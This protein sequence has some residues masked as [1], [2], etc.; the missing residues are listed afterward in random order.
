MKHAI[1]GKMNDTAST[2][3]ERLKWIYSTALCYKRNAVRKQTVDN[4][5]ALSEGKAISYINAD[6][7]R[8]TERR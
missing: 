6:K 2:E 4:D 1:K 3:Y 7:Y 8:K 5:A